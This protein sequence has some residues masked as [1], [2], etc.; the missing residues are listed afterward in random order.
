MA[1]RS[2]TKEKSVR[3]HQNCRST[4]GSR[5][6]LKQLRS[7]KQ[8]EAAQSHAECLA[9]QLSSKVSKIQRYSLWLILDQNALPDHAYSA[10]GLPNQLITSLSAIR[11]EGYQG[12]A[13]EQDDNKVQALPNGHM[14]AFFRWLLGMT[15]LDR[16]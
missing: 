3:R 4:S 9:P 8:M 14:A 12:L 5:T 16:S 2:S 10:A 15:V 13:A 11:S 1:L 6:K 7:V